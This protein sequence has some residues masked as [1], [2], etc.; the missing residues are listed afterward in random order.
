MMSLNGHFG[1]YNNCRLEV[2]GYK[3]MTHEEE[4]LQAQCTQWFHNTYPKHR[5]MLFHVDNNSWN[6]IIGAKKKA[7]GVCSG[8]TDLILILCGNV[9]FIE[10][11]TLTGELSEEQI[12]FM[13]KVK[14]RNHLHIVIRTF[15]SFKD[16]ITKLI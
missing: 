4:K 9:V 7:L 11:K 6:R 1:E 12:D 5:K 10:L 3:H 14:S 15:E 13:E 8:V 16:L 2:S